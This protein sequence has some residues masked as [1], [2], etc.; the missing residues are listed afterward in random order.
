MRA[1]LRCWSR[2]SRRSHEQTLVPCGQS[3]LAG[4]DPVVLAVGDLAYERGTLSEFE[5]CYAATWGA[6]KTRTY[7]VPESLPAFGQ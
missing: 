2:C 1:A 6:H 5:H 7:P 4:E 3:P